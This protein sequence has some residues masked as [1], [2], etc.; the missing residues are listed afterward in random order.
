MATKNMS[1]LDKIIYC[2]DKLEESRPFASTLN[3]IRKIAYDDIDKCSI[4]VMKDQYD[5]YIKNNKYVNPHLLKMI[6]FY[7]RKLV[8]GR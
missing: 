4:L 2:A 6:E 5:Y 7:E 1:K 8:D 3:D